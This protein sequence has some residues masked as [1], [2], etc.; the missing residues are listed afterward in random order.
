MRTSPKRKKQCG[1]FVVLKTRCDVKV[2]SGNTPEFG[3]VKNG[4]RGTSTVSLR[5]FLISLGLEMRQSIRA[6]DSKCF[7]QELALKTIN[8]S[9]CAI[10]RKPCDISVVTWSA[11]STLVN[12]RTKLW[13]LTVVV[14]EQ[15]IQ[16]SSG[17]RELWRAGDVAVKSGRGWP[18]AKL[19]E[20]NR[21]RSLLASA[22]TQ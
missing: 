4:V 5:H 12:T 19:L 2:F 13:C 6:L 11:K 15:V 7:L 21:F 18:L 14:V 16:S 10:T 17:T 8:G 3:N 1:G 20:R 22:L 9:G